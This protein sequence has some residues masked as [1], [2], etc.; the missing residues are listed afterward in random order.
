MAKKVADLKSFSLTQFLNIDY[1]N[2]ESEKFKKEIE[3]IIKNNDAKR[4]TDYFIYKLNQNGWEVDECYSI[5]HDKDYR[6]VFD[7]NIMTMVSELKDP[8]IHASFRFKNGKNKNANVDTI[9]HVLGLESQYIEKPKSG[10]YSWDNQIAYLVH[11]KDSDKYQYDPSEVYTAAGE[12]YIKIYH[13]NIEKWARGAIKKQNK[14]IQEDVDWLENEILQGKILRSQVML[15]D[16]YYK[17][18]ARNKRTID[19]AF[20]TYTQ[21]KMYRAIQ[22]LENGEFKTVVYYIHG[23][24]GD[25]K[26]LFAKD[27][28]SKII[29]DAKK[30]YNE[31]WAVCRAA[32]TNPVDDYAGEEILLMDDNRGSGMRADDWLKL[33]D[34][35]NINPSSARYR[36]K[37]VTAKFI[38]ITASIPPVEFFYYSKGVGGNSAQEEA[39]D[40]FLRRLMAT[41]RVVNTDKIKKIESENQLRGVQKVEIMR[42]IKGKKTPKLVSASKDGKE[43]TVSGYYNLKPDLNFKNKSRNEIINA[44][45]DEVLTESE[46]GNAENVIKSNKEYELLRKQLAFDEIIEKTNKKYSKD[47]KESN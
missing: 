39:I 32:S 9:A 34:P 42:S 3:E 6:E 41:I 14:K 37:A 19:D 33:L 15:S 7:S 10:K 24:S 44:L 23:E 16:E 40:Q 17:I 22:K 27:L 1:W 8:H 12:D 21:R 18:Y 29:S 36:N 26:S 35:Y 5:I 2:L 47:K 13:E 28:M 31:N 25:G 11:A 46:G 38:I 20:D 30:R 43:K 4:F 45:S